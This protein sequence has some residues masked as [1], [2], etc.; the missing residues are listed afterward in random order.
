MA[1]RTTIA[2]PYAQAV[3]ETARAHQTFAR[4]SEMLALLTLIAED[5]RLKPLIGNP[6]VTREVL[7]EVI[8]GVA[9]E[10]LDDS[11]RSLVRLLAENRR[12]DLLPEIRAHYE[13]YRAEAERVVEAEVISAFPV[14]D[15]QRGMIAAALKRRL[16]REIKLEC[17]TDASVIGGARIRAG[18]LVIDGSVAG[19]VDRLAGALSH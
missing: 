15:E 18:D 17:R 10:A 19:Y 14:T 2:R 9:G 6:R 3:F 11:A 4:W 13:E 16:G 1:E 8:L 7:V 5:E 12:L